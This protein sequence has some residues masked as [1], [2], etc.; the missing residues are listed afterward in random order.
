M[1]D[2][3]IHL[4]KSWMAGLEHSP[5]STCFKR[6]IKQRVVGSYRKRRA[7]KPSVFIQRCTYLFAMWEDFQSWWLREEKKRNGTPQLLAQPTFR[8]SN[9][10]Y[11]QPVL[12]QA[13]CDP[14][15]SFITSDCI[16]T[17]G[18]FLVFWFQRSQLL[19]GSYYENKFRVFSLN[20]DLYSPNRVFTNC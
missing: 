18:P 4:I 8:K 19:R 17:K 14:F 10:T 5:I 16:L 7:Q 20:Y 2:K 1:R 9:Q 13:L 3:P 15:Y 12:M 6:R 11:R